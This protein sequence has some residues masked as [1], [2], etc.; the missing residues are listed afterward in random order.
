MNARNEENE[1]GLVMGVVPIVDIS[2]KSAI[3]STTAKSITTMMGSNGTT[4]QAADIC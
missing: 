3:A 1:A 4:T 2:E